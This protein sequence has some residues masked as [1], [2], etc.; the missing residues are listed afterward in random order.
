MQAAFRNGKSSLH[1]LYLLYNQNTAKQPNPYETFP[2]H[3]RHLLHGDY[4]GHLH[5]QLLLLAHSGKAGA[6]PIQPTAQHRN[7][8]ALQRPD[9]LPIARRT[10]HPRTVGPLGQQPCRPQRLNHQ[11][12]RQTRFAQPQHYQRRNHPRLRIR[13]QAP[14]LQSE[15]DL[16]RPVR[17]R[18]PLLYP[19]F[20]PR[21][22]QTPAQPHHPRPAAG[23]RVARADYF[24]RHA[25]GRADSGL[26]FGKQH[27][28]THP[29]FGIRHEPS[30]RRR[31]G[32][33][34]IAAAGRP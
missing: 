5:R 23:T 32:C 33:T 16:L 6:K 34:R 27:L 4:F 11:G 31:I 7:Q 30:G 19:R 20:R 26:Y 18:I 2:P 12:Q 25:R 1:F 21:T 9:D 17:R 13:R 10:R 15:H 29:H 8:P 14:Q 22:S 24:C 28:Q 3:F